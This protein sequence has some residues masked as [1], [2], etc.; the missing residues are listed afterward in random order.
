MK[1][2]SLFD[3]I[4]CARVALERAGVKVETYYSSEIDNT[5][6]RIALKNYPSIIPVGRVEEIVVL[7]RRN[8]QIQQSAFD[9][10]NIDLLIGGRCQDLSAAKK[11]REGLKGKR[12]GLFY[13]YVSVL[14]ELKPKYFVLENVASMRV[15]DRDEITK[16]L[17]VE[18]I[19]IDAALVSAQSRRR[20]FWTN[21]PGITQPEDRGILLKDIVEDGW[22][23]SDKSRTLTASYAKGPSHTRLGTHREKT[24]V[25][26]KPIRIG[27]MPGTKG[28]Q[29]TRIYSLEGKSVSLPSHPGGNK[30]GL[31][32]V[33]EDVR[34]LTPTECERLQ[35]LP[36]GYTEGHS[37]TARITAL[38]NA[39]NVEVIAHIISH[40]P[41]Q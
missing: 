32:M 30:T 24:M 37:K 15:S 18:P 5:A 14:R 25:S 26:L 10:D 36:D 41:K 9:F 22:A 33:K 1:V 16:E 12:S 40:I 35:S 19:V 27:T 17:G 38:G 31:Y 20:L 7:H 4:A 29:G 2:L 23:M 34:P 8:K 3:G 13:E 39:F 21:I 6:I 11:G 28:G